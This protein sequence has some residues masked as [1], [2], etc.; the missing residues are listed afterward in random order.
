MTFLKTVNP[1]NCNKGGSF[2]NES[3]YKNLRSEVC[4]LFKPVN[5]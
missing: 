5:N 1:K 3:P 2:L 4:L